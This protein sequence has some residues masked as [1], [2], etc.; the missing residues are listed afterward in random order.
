MR[1]FKANDLFGMIGILPAIAILTG[2]RCPV[3]HSPWRGSFL[4]LSKAEKNKK[5]D[6][7]NVQF[8]VKLNRNDVKGW[9]IPL[10]IG[11]YENNIKIK[12]IT[13]NF[14]GPEVYD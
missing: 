10:E 13:A 11:L 3:I 4:R 6:Y 12:T 9:K 2:L 7:S 8:F 1:L 14:M 5:E